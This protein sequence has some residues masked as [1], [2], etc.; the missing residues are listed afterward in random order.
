MSKF[1]VLRDSG[2]FL[3]VKTPENN[4]AFVVASCTAENFAELITNLLTKDELE[5][6]QGEKNQNES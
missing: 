6:S 3:I 1:T 5:K 4:Q 2:K